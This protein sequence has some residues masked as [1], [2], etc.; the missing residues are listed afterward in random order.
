MAKLPDRYSL[1]GPESLRSGRQI[2]S[3]D[4]TAIGRGMQSLGS[5][6]QQAGSV[7]GQFA[8]K[9]KQKA[10]ALGIARANAYQ[11]QS[12]IE[13]ANSF[14]NDPD[15]ATFGARADE[16]ARQIA[17]QAAE[18]IPDP[19]ARELWKLQADTTAKAATDNVLDAGVRLQRQDDLVKLDEALEVQRRIYVDPNSSEAQRDAAR[20]KIEGTIEVA[21]GTGILLPDE[22]SN[23]KQVFLE[24]AD[25]ARAKLDTSLTDPRAGYFAAIRAAESGGND[26]AKNP[27]SSATGRYQFTESTWNRMVASYPGAGLTA[28]GRTD[29]AQQERA[30]RLFTAENE[31]VL[32]NAGHAATNGN[33]Y[34]A[35]FLGAGGATTVLGAPDGAALE[36]LL[37]TEVIK[38]NPFLKGMT[39]ADFKAWAD[40]K[41]GGD[42]V[43]PAYFERLSPEDRQVV[44]DMRETEARQ[45]ATAQAAQATIEYAN[46]DGQ[47]GLGILTGDVVSEQQILDAQLDDADKAKHLRSFRAE[48]DAV[49]DAQ[50]Y[51]SGLADGTAPTLNPYNSDDRSLVDKA[52]G[53]LLK[54]LPEDQRA[55]AGE[56]F[57]A[58]TGMV[59]DAVVADVRR[60]LG[61]SNPTAV[62]EGLDRAARLYDL[63]PQALSTVSN[64]K[65][66]AD[67]AI[68][69]DELVN[70]QGLNAAD[71]A[72]RMIAERDPANQKRREVLKPI[73]DQAIKDKQFK[74]EDLSPTFEGATTGLTP[75]QQGAVL[76]DYMGAVERAFM[77][78]AQGDIAIARRIAVEEMDNIYGVSEVSGQRA[79]M[80]F[81]PEKFYPP[82]EGSTSYVRDLAIKDARGIDPA[83]SNVMLTPTDQTAQD[84]RAGRAPR[85]DLW[86]QQ[87]DGVWAIAPGLFEVGQDE[88]AQLTKLGADERAIKFKLAREEKERQAAQPLYGSGGKTIPIY[89]GGQGLTPPA[90]PVVSPEDAARLQAI[91]AER[92]KVLDKQPMAPVETPDQEAERRWMELQSETFGSMGGAPK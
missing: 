32:A 89:G 40:D 74:I 78:P 16:K 6:I 34:A 26:S 15:Y 3:A 18:F 61:S 7:A 91:E 17:A 38:A 90:E 37:P 43:M 13:L 44:L 42:G 8:A 5:S 30:I 58:E 35:H 51:L 71:A 47:I 20:A 25:V 87:P 19:E 70:G 81:P 68:K 82:I 36:G 63:A 33:L 83:V 59:P 10:T 92:L 22:Y 77:G 4:T 29:P 41:A 55:A 73:W 66:I 27:N 76:S 84:V 60:S 85:Y 57:V 28:D 67:A 46:L 65:E 9:E 2:S 31:R 54:V 45:A 12:N 1:S 79:A 69:Y 80:K 64:G 14:A 62:A 21:K 52:Y 86:Y 48:Q 88:I 39:V 50:T 23:R 53:E 49:T 24:G 11:D 56:Q 72:Q 75:E